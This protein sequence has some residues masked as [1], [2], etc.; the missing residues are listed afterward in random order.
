MNL[1]ARHMGLNVRF[2]TPSEL[3]LKSTK[4]TRKI[5]F[6][7]T[8]FQVSIKGIKIFADFSTFWTV[9]IIRRIYGRV[10]FYVVYDARLISVLPFAFQALIQ[11]FRFAFTAIRIIFK[12]LI[13]K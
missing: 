11:Q 10:S 3:G 12:L 9:F 2:Q 1:T 7:L 8:D 4:I 13:N 6:S 5:R